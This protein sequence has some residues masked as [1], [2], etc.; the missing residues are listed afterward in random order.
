MNLRTQ[1]IFGQNGN[2][3]E[4]SN[5]N[6]PRKSPSIYKLKQ[7]AENSLLVKEEITRGFRKYFELNDNGNI[8]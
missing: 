6:I 1:I 3:L 2:Q 4:A 7:Y 8:T 5:K